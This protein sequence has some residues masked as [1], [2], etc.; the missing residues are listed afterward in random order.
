M[1]QIYY[2]QCLVSDLD[3]HQ[4]H[5]VLTW[6]ARV[7]HNVHKVSDHCALSLGAAYPF[8]TSRV[9][10]FLPNPLL[11]L[12]ADASGVT[13]SASVF[14]NKI[15]NLKLEEISFSFSFVD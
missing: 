2:K 3:T 14:M 9:A 11:I 7:Y 12:I 6:H 5:N 8:C 10:D 1:A 15:G 13:G 4:D